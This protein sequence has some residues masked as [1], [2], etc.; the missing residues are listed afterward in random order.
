SKRKVFVDRLEDHLLYPGNAAS[1]NT[2]DSGFARRW[3]IQRILKLGWTVERFG[4]FDRSVNRCTDDG[5]RADKPERIGKKYQWI[6]YYEMLA[7]IADNFQLKKECWGPS[8]ENYHGPWTI[9]Y[10]R[11][12]DPSWLL[13]Q[14]MAEEWKP[15]SSTWWFLVTHDE[16]DG[17][18]SGT[19]WL[20]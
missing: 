16:W 20:K 14:T 9:G 6:A 11:D 10:R 3:M 4:R 19:D 15:H 2:F 5:R 1:G 7:R 12:I 13:S 18:L 8:A 17:D